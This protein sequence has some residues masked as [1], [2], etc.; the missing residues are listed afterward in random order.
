MHMLPIK[1][2]G[3]TWLIAALLSTCALWASGQEENAPTSLDEQTKWVQASL[4][5][6]SQQVTNL[7]RMTTQA[8]RALMQQGQSVRLQ[9]AALEEK[10]AAL[11]SRLIT[12]LAESQQQLAGLQSE[13]QQQLDA[14][15]K[16]SQQQRGQLQNNHRQLSL[17]LWALTGLFV[18]M[19]IF[20]A[21][22]WR[23]RPAV[24]TRHVGPS[25]APE[26]SSP[27]PTTTPE[28]DPMP[29]AFSKAAAPHAVDETATQRFS[30][31]PEFFPDTDLNTEPNPSNW[32]NANLDST[33]QA[34]NHARQDFMQ[35][36]RI[37]K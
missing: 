5:Q 22:L 16:E 18:L 8:D 11:Q 13:S 28:P 36:A 7:R 37:D 35:P 20:F 15:L 9:L 21:L 29:S 33:A 3:L 24:H 17:V 10:Q 31:L 30:S 27:T 1:R 12:L 4:K 25:P 26:V 14:L 19:L 23:T 32:I 2:S 34:L 6:L